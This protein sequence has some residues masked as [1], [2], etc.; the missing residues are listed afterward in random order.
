MTNE[1]FT[2]WRKA[3]YS[4]QNGGCIEVAADRTVV[5]VR[6]TRQHGRGPVL[7]FPETAWR[8]FIA[9]ARAV[10]LP[11]ERDLAGQGLRGPWRAGPCA[12]AR[13]R[14]RRDTFRMILRIT[15]DCLILAAVH[16]IALF[17]P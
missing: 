5:G 11:R 8:A 4:G 13:S 15:S 1:E 3:S 10:R 12:T 17:M 9:G 2:G 16:R 7:E 6:D 14:V